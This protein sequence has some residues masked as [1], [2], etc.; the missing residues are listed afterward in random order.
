MTG[1]P[2]SPHRAQNRRGIIEARRLGS[3]H[4]LSGEGHRATH[5]APA[6]AGAAGT[7]TSPRAASARTTARSAPRTPPAWSASASASSSRTAPTAWPLAAARS[8]GSLDRSRQFHLVTGYRAGVVEPDL[9]VS[10]LH[11]LNELDLVAGDLA[12]LDFGLSHHL[13]ANRPGE[14]FAICL[15]VER[16]DHRPLRPLD[17]CLPFAV[18]L[19]RTQTAQRRGKRRNC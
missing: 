12:V 17:L 1:E 14:H 3:H 11:D 8:A 2:A 7:S 6:P 10:P 15:Q 13:V 5:S 9:E 16:K 18:H 19:R 4:S